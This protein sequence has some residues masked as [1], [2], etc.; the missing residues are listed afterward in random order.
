MSKNTFIGFF[1]IC[2]VSIALFGM[3]RSDFLGVNHADRS[4]VKA[5][6]PRVVGVVVPMDHAA[7]REI[8]SGFKDTLT[9][10]F[11]HPV[12]IK[13]QNAQGDIN[14]QHSIIQ[15]FI[16]ANVDV[17]VPIGTAA[18]QMTV[19]M[20]KTQPIVSLAA[21]YTE[22]E[23]KTQKDIHLTGVLDEI[24]PQK[25]LDLMK[26][27]FP[28]L[29]KITLVY[30]NTEKVFPEVEALLAYA[31][32]K[33]IAVQKLMVQSLPEL[34]TLSNL[35]EPDSEA[36]FVLKDHLIVSGM[37]TLIQEAR[38][39]SIPVVTCDEGSIEQGATFALGV[40]ENAIG[41]LGG[42]MVAKLLQGIPI[43]DLP[44]ERITQLS[45]FYNE[46][47]YKTLDLELAKLQEIAKIHQY[48]LVKK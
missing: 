39:R 24:G 19:S 2:L 10:D 17:V 26:E 44:V 27:V 35:I 23:R 43:K 46:V 32:Q 6:K 45:V 14:L 40:Q 3:Y 8:V 5:L 7:L 48:E 30:S 11:A 21:L 13:V 22:T 16:N 31:P 25:P 18:T 42:A 38:K 36:I 15:Q 12:T 4:N 34:Y 29:K 41:A 9:K 37:P 47:A 1:S 28:Q 33:G 20:V